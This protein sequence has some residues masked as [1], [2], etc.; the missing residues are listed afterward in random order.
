MKVTIKM[1]QFAVKYLSKLSPGMGVLKFPTPIS[2]LVNLRINQDQKCLPE[3]K[4]EKHEMLELFLTVLSDSFFAFIKR[5][6]SG[7]CIFAAH[8]KYI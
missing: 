2:P 8:Q 6:D 3:T 1:A 5:H 4:Y 7:F